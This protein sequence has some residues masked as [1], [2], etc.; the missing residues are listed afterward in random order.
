MVDIGRKMYERNG[1]E[2]IVDNDGI[3]WLNEK[4]IEGLDYK[5]VREIALK[6]NSNHRIHRHELV[7]EPKKHVNRI[8]V[9]N[10]ISF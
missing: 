2:I 8:F 3:L 6:Y 4:H 1:I 9:D 5:N 10:M 7:Q